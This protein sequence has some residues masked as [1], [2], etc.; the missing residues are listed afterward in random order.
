VISRGLAS[1][2]KCAYMVP[3]KV[4]FFLKFCRIIPTVNQMLLL[5]VIRM[6]SI[7]NCGSV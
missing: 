1:C 4:P 2:Q 7:N 5:Y 3:H 6:K